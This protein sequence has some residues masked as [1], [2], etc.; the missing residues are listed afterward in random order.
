ML[1]ALVFASANLILYGNLVDRPKLFWHPPSASMWDS[2]ARTVLSWFVDAQI[3]SKLPTSVVFLFVTISILI[4]IILV[5]S[6]EKNRAEDSKAEFRKNTRLLLVYSAIAYLILVLVTIYWLDR[7]TPL[8]TRI[9]TPLYLF[10]TLI[11]V[12]FLGKLWE[13]SLSVKFIIA[14]LITAIVLFQAYRGL[15]EVKRLRINGL[16]LTTWSWHASPSMQ[17]IQQLP[18]IRIYTNDIPAIYFLAGRDSSFI[19]TR[20]N[21]AVDESRSDYLER[22]REMHWDINDEDAILVILGP[23]ASSKLDPGYMNDL[24]EG[25]CLYAEF[26]DGM[27]FRRCADPLS[28]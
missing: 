22:L 11:L 26:Q 24:T 13:K 17:S 18:N 12:S 5:W 25:L 2:G 9:L 23:G 10:C 1:P 7:L 21:P 15:Q 14:G 16:G 3:I 6:I 28:N 19:P 20:I 8:D 27:F 4:F